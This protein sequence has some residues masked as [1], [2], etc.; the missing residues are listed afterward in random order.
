MAVI[1]HFVYLAVF[2]LMLA[3]GINLVLTVIM[4][5]KKQSFGIP[6]IIAAYGRNFTNNNWNVLFSKDCTIDNFT[7]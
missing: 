5:L 7:V 2:F 6:M 3:Q 4:P 1:L